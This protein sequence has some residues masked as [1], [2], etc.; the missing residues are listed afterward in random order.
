[1]AVSIDVKARTAGPCAALT[2]VVVAVLLVGCHSR[3]RQ[4]LG[5]WFDSRPFRLPT[6]V[7]ERLGGPLTPGELAAIERISRTE[8]AH[9]FDG[10]P[11]VLTDNH[12]AFW[13]I[14]VVPT[15][16]GR[17]RIRCRTRASRSR[18]D[19]SGIG[20][21]RVRY[22]CCL[23]DGVRAGV[24]DSSGHH[25]GDWTGHRPRGGSRVRAS[26]PRRDDGA[27]RDRHEQL[28]IRPARSG[29]AVLSEICTGPTGG[30]S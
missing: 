2:A 3:A 8:L 17:V 10:L 23:R 1:M 26:N 18:S 30:R 29:V 14:E 9:A 13:K 6:V 12:V 24:G 11:L 4:M 7:G 5:F 27:Q 22:R 21:R 20:R 25:R 28:R 19:H 16:P 15:L